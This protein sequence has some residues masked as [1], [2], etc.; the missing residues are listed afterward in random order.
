MAAGD[1]TITARWRRAVAGWALPSQSICAVQPLSQGP[2]YPANPAR[3]TR[4]AAAFGNSECPGHQPLGHPGKLGEVRFALFEKSVFALLALL[5]HV[6]EHGGISSQVEQTH[7][8]VT[9]GIECGL[10][11]AQ[12]NG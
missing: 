1:G 3:W 8:A 5:A 4:C 12:R 10:E 6:V 2:L 9:V 7:L 11:A